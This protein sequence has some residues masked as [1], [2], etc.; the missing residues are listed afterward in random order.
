L[1]YVYIKW[2]LYLPVGWDCIVYNRTDLPTEAFR[3]N[4]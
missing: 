3:L 1:F 4:K 2:K